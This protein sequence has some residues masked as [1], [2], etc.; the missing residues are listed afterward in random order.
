VRG[1]LERE[2]TVADVA[3]AHVAALDTRI[4]SL[5]LVRAVLSVVARRN[6]DNEEMA[7]MNKLARLSAAERKQI[8]GPRLTAYACPRRSPRSA[9]L[10]L[11]SDPSDRHVRSRGPARTG[12]A[13]PPQS[14]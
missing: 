2:V 11:G 8:V 4:R 10:R 1:V 5:R 12:R 13:G 14:P 7:L 3:A 9:R 6:P